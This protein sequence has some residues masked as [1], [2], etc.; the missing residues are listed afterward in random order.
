MN[1]QQ[2]WKENFP[3]QIPPAPFYMLKAILLVN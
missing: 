2:L 1:R 3:V